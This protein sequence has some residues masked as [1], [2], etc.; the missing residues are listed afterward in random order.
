VLVG[1][2]SVN[3]ADPRRFSR[4]VLAAVY[5]AGCRAVIARGWMGLG[6][7][8]APER[9]FFCDEVPHR[10]LLPHLAGIA[11]HGGSGTVHSAARA[12]IPQF[13]MPQLADQFY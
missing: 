5:R 2:G 4:S 7:Y 11:H 12:G 3:V 10:T 1:F 8:G 6:G 13:V 9:V